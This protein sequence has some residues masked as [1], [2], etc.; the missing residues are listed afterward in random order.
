[1]KIFRNFFKKPHREFVGFIDTSFIEGT[2]LKLIEKKHWTIKIKEDRRLKEL[3]EPNCLLFISNLNIYEIKRKLMKEYNVPLSKVNQL[4]DEGIRAFKNIKKI[5]PPIIK[6]N[7]ALIKWML[8]NNLEFKDGI[9]ID[10]AQKFNVPFITSENN[11]RVWKGAYNGVM[12]QKEFWE[13]LK[14]YSSR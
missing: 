14:E 5:E 10:I 9:L 13:K 7:N 3:N 11:A 1:M 4:Y 2:F 12:S 6:V 8:E